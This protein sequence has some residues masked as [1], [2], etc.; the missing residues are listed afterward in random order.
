MPRLRRALGREVPGRDAARRTGAQLAELVRLEHR[1]ELRG[2]GAEEEDDEARTLAEAGVD[3]RACVAEL[4][5]GGSHDGERTAFQPQAIPGP[6]L[7]AASRHPAEARLDR[8]HGVGRRQ[9]LGD[10]LL[11]EIEG[12]LREGLYRVLPLCLS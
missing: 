2:V 7:D 12:H 3:L 8:F 4:E 6:V 1:D 10:V 9:E 5:V 11:R